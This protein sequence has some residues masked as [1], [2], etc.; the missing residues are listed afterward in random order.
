VPSGVGPVPVAAV[1]RQLSDAFVKIVVLDGTDVTT[2]CHVGR[3]VSRHIQTALEER[4]PVCVV[5]KCEVAHGLED[6]HWDVPYAE[7]GTSTLAGLARICSW[8]HGLATYEGLVLGGGA[9]AWEWSEP[10]GGAAF[11]TGPPGSGTGFRD[12]G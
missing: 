6:H 3:S 12:T 8:H 2:V 7:C 4:D 9:G 1:H 11:E 5:P 10:P